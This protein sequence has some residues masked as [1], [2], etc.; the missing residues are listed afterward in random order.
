[1]RL[2]KRV[3]GLIELVH[4]DVLFRYTFSFFLIEI[5]LD[6]QCP[7]ERLN[8]VLVLSLILL[9]LLGDHVMLFRVLLH[10]VD[11]L[12]VEMALKVGVLGRHVLIDLL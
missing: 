3:L 11:V 5:L 4:F 2:L 7:Q 1:M 6:V 9:Q 8:K 12:F 10:E